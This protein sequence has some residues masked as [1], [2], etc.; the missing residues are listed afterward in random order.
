MPT[1][2]PIIAIDPNRHLVIE[3]PLFEEALA[4][5]RPTRRGDDL[6]SS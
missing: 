3:K 4:R 2:K 5:H 1:V 6:L